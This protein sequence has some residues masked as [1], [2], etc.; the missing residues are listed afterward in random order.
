MAENLNFKIGNSRCYKDLDNNCKKYGRLYD[1]NAAL[2]AC[3]AGWRLPT[4]QEWENLRQVAGG[5]NVAGMKLK[6]KTGWEGYYDERTGNGEDTFGF[7]ALPG[8]MYEYSS[9]DMLVGRSGFWW[10]N[11][12][13]E[14]VKRWDNEAYVWKMARMSHSMYEST[15]TILDAYSVRCVLKE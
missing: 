2:K 6:S 10:S 11:W 13:N 7:S 8:G 3:P 15:T 14:K 9:R 1:H 5:E 12:T 4:Y